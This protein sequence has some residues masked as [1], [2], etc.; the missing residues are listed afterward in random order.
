MTA[1]E[2]PRLLDV[3]KPCP[4]CN[5]RAFHISDANMHE[6][7]I[8]THSDGCFFLCDGLPTRTQHIRLDDIAAWNRRAE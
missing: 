4:F 1:Y 6:W 5:A 7:V 3:I 8:V 2:K